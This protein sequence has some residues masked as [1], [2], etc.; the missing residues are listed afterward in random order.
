MRSYFIVSRPRRR[1]MGSGGGGGGE[2]LGGGYRNDLRPGV[3]MSVF[4]CVRPPRSLS[5]QFLL[6][7]LCDFLET[8]QV[9]LLWYEDVLVVLD[10]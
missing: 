8:L 1:C 4:L 2:G 6:G 3:C 5:P 7:I 9:F 10:F